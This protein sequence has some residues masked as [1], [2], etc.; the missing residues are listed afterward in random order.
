[1]ANLKVKVE[2]ESERLDESDLNDG[3]TFGVYEMDCDVKDYDGE[4]GVGVY[5]V[6]DARW[7]K[8][9]K[10]RDE[11]FSSDKSND[12]YIALEL[13]TTGDLH[14]YSIVLLSFDETTKAV[15]NK[16]RETYKA[17]I[18]I[19]PNI[20]KLTYE[21]NH[22]LSP[23]L[24]TDGFEYDYG[25][26][27]DGAAI[28]KVTDEDFEDDADSFENNE[29]K[30]DSPILRVFEDGIQIIFNSEFTDDEAYA[31]IKYE[32]LDRLFL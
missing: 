13:N 24:L 15:I 9:E 25:M 4:S 14:G 2:W 27:K 7:Y 10:E 23:M 22:G 21:F 18:V 11:D 31:T 16:L 8:T 20:S 32:Q 26:F 29:Y 30:L 12:E 28:I 3:K 19:D 5:D 6:L 17:V 1:M